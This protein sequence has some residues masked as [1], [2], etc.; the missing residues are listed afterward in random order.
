MGKDMNEEDFI[1]HLSMDDFGIDE[2]ELRKEVQQLKLKDCPDFFSDSLHTM[3]ECGVGWMKTAYY[4]KLGD[5][6][7]DENPIIKK[8]YDNILRVI[9]AEK[10]SNDFQVGARPRVLFLEAGYDLPTHS[11][12]RD[13]QRNHLTVNYICSEEASPIN[14]TEYGSV[15]YNFALIN[16]VEEHSVPKSNTDRY[17]IGVPIRYKNSNSNWDDILKVVKNDNIDY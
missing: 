7:L 5:V 12:G 14:F 10:I 11:H 3:D 15:N 17:L 6:I 8:F 2:D 1:Y 16:T 9:K 13:R 4:W